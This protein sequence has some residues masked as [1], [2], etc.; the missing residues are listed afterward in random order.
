MENEE[1]IAELRSIQSRGLEIR[2]TL[3]TFLSQALHDQV[4]GLSDKG[5]VRCPHSALRRSKSA[6]YCA[7]TSLSA[8]L[9]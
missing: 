2:D 7:S 4:T 9:K 8:C 6:P 3:E 5:A 1:R